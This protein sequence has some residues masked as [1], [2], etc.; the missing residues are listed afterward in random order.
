MFRQFWLQFGTFVKAADFIRGKLSRAA[1]VTAHGGGHISPALGLTSSEGLNIR[2]QILASMMSNMLH[3]FM[4][5][6]R[7]L[8]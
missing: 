8:E 1:L 2:D 4:L 5:N 6:I 7:L 3:C